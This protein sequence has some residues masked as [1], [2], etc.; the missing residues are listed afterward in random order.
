MSNMIGFCE[1]SPLISSFFR[2]FASQPKFYE[3][4]DNEN[5]DGGLDR[6]HRM[7][8]HDHDGNGT[9]MGGAG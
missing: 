5:M 9:K 6:L 8:V 4:E 2:N 7:D 1:K 3:Y